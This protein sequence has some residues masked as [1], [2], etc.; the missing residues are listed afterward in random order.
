MRYLSI[1]MILAVLVGCYSCGKKELRY[2]Q[3]GDG[4]LTLQVSSMPKDAG[5]TAAVRSYKAVIIPSAKLT[6]KKSDGDSLLFRMDSC[7][8]LQRAGAKIYPYLVQEIPNGV[9]GTFEY[10][11]EFPAIVNGKGDTTRFIYQD[12]FINKKIYSITAELQ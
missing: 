9:R 1:L 10:L 3:A 12:R 8:Y 2:R 6:L 4:D 7:F 5:D 11:V